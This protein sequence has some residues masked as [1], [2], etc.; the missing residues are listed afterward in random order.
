V[1]GFGEL[2]TTRLALGQDG[3][4]T[5]LCTPR[6]AGGGAQFTMTSTDSGRSFVRGNIKAL[7]RAPATALAASSAKTIL[8]SLSGGTYRS[9]DGGRS[10]VRL[11]GSGA[12]GSV[13]WLGFENARDARAVSA[14]G[15][16]IWTTHDSGATWSAVTFR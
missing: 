14:D 2:D 11:D 8:V 9:T 15:R 3:S 4:V 1:P 6:Q 7:G 12:P 13:D 10:Y 16:T 5:V